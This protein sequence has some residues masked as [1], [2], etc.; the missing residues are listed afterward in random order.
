MKELTWK[1]TTAIISTEGSEQPIL[2][3][4]AVDSGTRLG[5]GR[6]VGALVNREEVFVL[7]GRGIPL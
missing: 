5:Y 1:R 2:L 4:V 7:F 3:Q 6:I